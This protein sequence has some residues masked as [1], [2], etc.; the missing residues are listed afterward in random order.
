M[1]DHY[2][3]AHLPSFQ[4]KGDGDYSQREENMTWESEVTEVIKLR[5][6]L[7]QYLRIYSFFQHYKRQR[8]VCISFQSSRQSDEYI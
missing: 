1:F 2:Q 3:W 4:F 7:V 6:Q 5:L 8:F